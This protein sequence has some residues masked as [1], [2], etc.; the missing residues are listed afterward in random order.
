MRWRYW[1]AE[2]VRPPLIEVDGTTIILHPDRIATELPLE[3]SA[4][5][6]FPSDTPD[7]V[8][9]ENDTPCIQ[10][11]VDP[12]LN[13]PSLAGQFLHTS[14]RVL[15]NYGLMIDGIITKTADESATGTRRYDFD[16]AIRFQPTFLSP[17]AHKNSETIGMGLFS[18]GLHFH[19]YVTPATVRACCV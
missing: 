16:E 14:I 3:Y 13:N 6:R 8:V 10:Y 1:W 15:D 9:Y 4:V 18:R 19:G 2:K 7:I 5:I 11:H 12:L 17:S